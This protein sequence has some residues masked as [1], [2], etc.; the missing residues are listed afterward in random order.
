MDTNLGRVESRRRG[1]TELREERGESRWLPHL[2]EVEDIDANHGNL[3][4]YFLG[5]R[6]RTRNETGALS[7][8]SLLFQPKSGLFLW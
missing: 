8:K 5:E 1:S 2:R 3:L 6:R 4:K 7:A